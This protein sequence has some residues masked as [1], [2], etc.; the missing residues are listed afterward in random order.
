MLAPDVVTL[1]T[2]REAMETASNEPTTAPSPLVQAPAPSRV[3]IALLAAP[4]R[5]GSP[6]PYTLA[7]H[8]SN[9]VPGTKV[10]PQFVQIKDGPIGR[11]AVIRDNWTTPDGVDLWI[12]QLVDGGGRMH[13]HPKRTTQCS[14]LDG[15]C[16]CAGECH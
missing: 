6:E 15:H 9:Y 10:V 8:I 13:V 16:M 2:N 5:P 14:R 1:T 12:V 11:C 4:D 3:A 7:K